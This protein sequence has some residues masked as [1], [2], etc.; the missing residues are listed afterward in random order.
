MKPFFSKI[1]YL[2]TPIWV[3]ESFQNIQKYLPMGKSIF[4]VTDENVYHHWKSLFNGF[5]VIVLPAGEKEKSFTQIEG[6]IEE[7][8]V[9][10][11]DRNSF[12]LGVGG[13]V[14]CDIT[15]FVASIFMRGIPFAFAPTT[16]LAQ[17]DASIGG[18]NGVNTGLYKNMV[19]VFNQPNFILTDIAFLTTLPQNEFI[20]GLAEVIKHACIQ[21]KIYFIAIEKQIIGILGRDKKVLQEIILESIHIKTKI[22]A[23]DP[24]EKGKR[25][26]LNFGHTF[27]HAI[28]KIQ[29]ISH[30]KAVSLGMIMVNKI[31]VKEGFLAE[32]KAIRIQKLL[33][34]IG[35]PTDIPTNITELLPILKKD[36]KKMG[37]KLSLILLKDIG[38]GFIHPVSMEKINQFLI[39]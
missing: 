28:E 6:I 9:R 12:L 26:L 35:L 29:G 5:S 10:N 8:I 14:I 19:G 20:D 3:G 18:K 23:A 11:A 17:I 32:K 24:L 36:K 25:K 30:G 4:I 15:G 34:N 39:F 7:L 13:G 38:K 31:A 22:V 16:L 33:E 2:N 1:T 21:N 37:T 27:G